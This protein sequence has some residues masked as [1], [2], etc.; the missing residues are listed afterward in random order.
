MSGLA[1]TTIRKGGGCQLSL[2]NSY[3]YT[4]LVLIHS[5]ETSL[6]TNYKNMMGLLARVITK[7]IQ[8]L[9]PRCVRS[10]NL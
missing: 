2:R 7:Q 8:T 5:V 1:K 4:D 3:N 6:E 10:D 9:K